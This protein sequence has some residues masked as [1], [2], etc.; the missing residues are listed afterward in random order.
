LQ[1]LD[2]LRT[3]LGLHRLDRRP[4]QLPGAG[5]FDQIVLPK[6]LDAH[7]REHL[8][9]LYGSLAA[10]VLAPAAEDPSLLERLH[11]DG[12]DIEAQVRYALTHE[13]ARSA[14]DVLRRRTT[15]FYRGLVDDALHDRVE[16]VL[17]SGFGRASL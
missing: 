3:D 1:A 10:E 7:V 8:L 2:R 5:G 12:P 13:W 4:W 15:C 16:R 17:S 11:P 6:S 14:D 9:H